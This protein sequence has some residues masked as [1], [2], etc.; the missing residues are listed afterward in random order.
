MDR[1]SAMESTEQPWEFAPLGDR[2]LL[3]QW[4]G[5]RETALDAVLAL[6]RYI[7]LINAPGIFDLVPGIDSLLVCYDPLVTAPDGL[8]GLLLTDQ[9]PTNPTPRSP[10]EVHSIPVVYGGQDG[11]DLAFVAQSAGLSESEVITLHTA[12]PMP[13][14]IV[15]FMPGFPYI[16]ELPPELRLPRRAEPRTTVPAGSVAVANDQTGIYPRRSPGGW[17]L[18]GRTDVALFDPSRE[19]PALLQAG[20]YVQFVAS[21]VK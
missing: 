9:P 5:S 6:C 19:P 14:L 15:G 18:I 13:V 4:R 7:R 16:G 11:P 20:D 2:G 3:V 17:H 12:R 8:K 10:G 1:N 21:P